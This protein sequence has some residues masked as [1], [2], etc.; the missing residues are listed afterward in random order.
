MGEYLEIKPQVPDKMRLRN[1][2]NELKEIPK[3]NNL[4]KT[5]MLVEEMLRDPEIDAA[6]DAT[7]HMIVQYLKYNDH[8]RAH[9]IITARNALKILI[10][11]KDSVKPNIV[12]SNAGTFDDAAAIVALA[13][14][15]HDLGNM[16]HREFHYGFSLMVANKIIWRYVKKFW[17]KESRKK[18]WLIYAHIANAVYSHDDKVFAYTV[19][20]SVVKAADGCDMAAGRSR[21]PYSI[22]KV[23][24]HSVSALSIIEVDIKRGERKPV[25]IEVNMMDAAGI[26]QVEEVLMK[27]IKTGIIAD[28][29]EVETFVNGKRVKLSRP[30]F[31][32]E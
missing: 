26:F 18:K 1:I 4:E 23:D 31:T 13:A 6:Q 11:L 10:L 17:D 20:G 21:M 25:R 7:N 12:V 19:E 27:K 5:A 22:G 29:I 24:I 2:I 30:T 3:R 8:G 32:L 15:I 16:V 9:A 14:F 28:Y